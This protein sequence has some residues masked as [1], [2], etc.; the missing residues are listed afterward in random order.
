MKKHLLRYCVFAISIS[1]L[2]LACRK[3]LSH[4]DPAGVNG[5][6]GPID[7]SSECGAPVFK[8]LWDMGGAAKR[9]NV[10]IVNDNDKITLRVSADGPVYVKRIIAVFGSKEHVI[11]T[12]TE[13]N[14]WT[15][16]DGPPHPDRVKVSEPL[17]AAD[18][19][20]IPNS[21]FQN[22]SCVWMSVFVTLT[23]DSG[24]EWCTFQRP[25]DDSLQNISIWKAFF[26]YCRQRCSE[27]P[28]PPEC[29]P[30]KK[31]LWD[32]GEVSIRGHME[33]TNDNEHLF[34]KVS[35]GQ[36]LFVKKIIA[37][38][39]SNDH[40]RQTLL[41]TNLW[42]PCD[43]PAHPDRVKEVSAGS[44]MDTLQIPASAFGEDS[45]TWLAV[46]VTLT[47]GN[48]FEWCT[49]PR[50]AD[51]SIQNISVWKSFFRYCKQHCPGEPP[52]EPHDSCGKLR[53]Q[54]PGGW[55]AE[56]HGNNPG[57]YLHANFA[58]A[59]PNGLTVGCF[60]ADFYISLTSA[61]AITAY[62]PS[63]GEAAALT[64]NYTDPKEKELK[65]SL[66]HHL[67]ALTL[68]VGFDKYDPNFGE[69]EIHL[70]DM[71]IAKGT[72]E[73]WTVNAFLAAA[74]KALGGC[75]NTY[76]LK[77]L[78]EVAEHINECCKKDSDDDH[79]EG[80]DGDNDDN[81]DNNEHHDEHHNCDFL[82]C[83]R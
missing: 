81:D 49:F 79:H 35:A 83:P 40:V 22:D 68:N 25:N 80:E 42:T 53:T 44:V 2:F 4:Q 18:T 52:G 34:L 8:E 28:P 70:G 77:Q 31:N 11:N 23:D 1:A 19:M 47:N 16:C 6:T 37:V 30:L 3:E 13:T 74:N 39:G 7:S 45:C 14:L 58:A 10:V 24:F 72:F 82:R 20:Q 64:K 9:G 59:F 63:G 26:K 27:P 62:L 32:Q 69:A 67:V 73:G 48:G 21:A 46:Y 75:D 66:A 51:D 43:G 17:L 12:L 55:G 36:N 57:T 29:E 56:P 78:T 65:N 60:P 5:V 41:E 15:P 76:K 33:V 61:D 71:I 38:F 50:P 54:T